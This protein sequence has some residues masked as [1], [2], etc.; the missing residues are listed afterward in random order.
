VSLIDLTDWRIPPEDK[1]RK[2][3][4]G[5]QPAH[6]AGAEAALLAACMLSPERA[7]TILALASPEDFYGGAHRAIARAIADL[8]EVGTEP[9]MV[10]VHSRLNATG[11]APMAGGMGGL[12]DLVESVPAIANVETY[13]T[14]VRD[15]ATVR[16]LGEALHRLLAE[17]YGPLPDVG[18]FLANVDA[19]IGEVV[20]TKVRTGAVTALEATKDVARELTTAPEATVTTGYA[21]LDK[22]TRGFERGAFY[23]LAARTGMGK[24]AMA[25]TMAVA[26]ASTG[27]PVLFVS[28]EMSRQQLMRRMVCQRAGIPLT[29]LRN[30]EMTPRQW[31]LFTQASSDLAQ[32][33]LSISDRP[34]QSLL[35]VKALVRQVKPALLVVDHIGLLKSANQSGKQNR[36]QEV[37]AFSR[38]LKVLAMGEGLPVMALC[39]VGR[40]VAKG[41][42]RP[43]VSDLRESGDIEQD[44]D[45]IWLIHRPGYYDPKASPE[46]RAQ[47]ELIVGKQRDGETPILPMRWVPELPAFEEVREW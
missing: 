39:Q 26:A 33:P 13:A 31:S 5:K 29:A 19:T 23:V 47:A 35:D 20:R 46:V 28:L 1:S 7:P 12:A 30:R 10:A 8:L 2:V 9:D 27:A 45:G 21:S 34:G 4:D 3:I 17:C 44:A 42:R 37:G 25:T 24:T 41:A 6:D 15:L 16:R 40:D 36:T 11:K 32:M 14:T 38:G 22:V 43:L 18:A